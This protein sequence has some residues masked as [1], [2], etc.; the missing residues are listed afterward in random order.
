[1]HTHKGVQYYSMKLPL[2][3]LPPLS[4][5][6][7][8]LPEVLFQ[9]HNL[10]TQV[11]PRKPKLP[12]LQPNIPGPPIC[13]ESPS[14]HHLTYFPH[15]TSAKLTILGIDSIFPTLS[16]F[17]LFY[18]ARCPFHSPPRNASTPHP[19]CSTARFPD[20]ELSLKPLNQ[21]RAFSF[22]T[23]RTFD[24]QVSI[25]LLLK[26]EQFDTFHPFH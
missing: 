25:S 6:L 1:M 23:C 3:L 9:G 15:K 5:V 18:P 20:P 26:H 14:V 21:R 4:P 22:C 8:Q 7:H 19:S 12:N 17:N 24:S 2:Q 11:C 13:P 10:K 16:F